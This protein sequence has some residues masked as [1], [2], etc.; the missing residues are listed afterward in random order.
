M[1]PSG[2]SSA[3][4]K[5]AAVLAIVVLSLAVTCSVLAAISRY[6]PGLSPDS[7]NYVSAA[8]SLLTGDGMLNKADRPLVHWPPLLPAAMAL[9][10][11]TGISVVWL[12]G[13]LNAAAAGATAAVSGLW[14]LR[15]CRLRVMAVLGA[16]WVAAS[17][18]MFDVSR[19][20]WSE[21]LFILFTV[22]T[23]W[24]IQRYLE[25]PRTRTLVAAGL[26]AALAS[27]T[28]YIGVT[29]TATGCLL[30]L[31]GSRQAVRKR[32]VACL[33]FGAVAG[34]PLAAWLVRNWA[35]GGTL[36]GRRFPSNVGLM[37]NVSRAGR[38]MARFLLP[39][40]KA[41][42]LPGMVWFGAM[43]GG[44]L[45]LAILAAYCRRRREGAHGPGPAASLLTF[46]AVYGGSLLASATLVALTSIEGR[47]I[48][49]LYVPGVL[50][51]FFALDEAVPLARQGTAGGSRFPGGLSGAVV[52][53]ALLATVAWGGV[54]GVW[55]V[56]RV[57]TCMRK[58]AGGFLTA[59][60]DESGTIGFLRR[61]EVPLPIYSNVPEAIG[62]WTGKK[63]VLTPRETV[64]GSD[65]RSDPGEV[66]EFMAGAADSGGAT[67]VWFD[68]YWRQNLYDLDALRRFV[69][70][71]RVARFPDA[72][73]YRMTARRG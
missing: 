36:A 15:S 37:E 52:L 9:L 10:G 71:E 8:R 51:V 65:M 30:F 61:S 55:C 62:I 22:L 72:T 40:G 33:L 31:L 2:T 16:V 73:V 49:P 11:L 18:P 23:L 43:A 64:L 69:E 29:V 27:L 28:R 3:A 26:L 17:I 1:E 35:V 38:G 44:A 12:G 19:M 4:S 66:T 67:L 68:S 6:G 47:Y 53:A 41:E 7:L 70:L 63:A 58:G 20:L 42:A 34:L 39:A 24:Q 59:Q 46:C 54:Y 50:L 13:F 45:A 48:A 25:S 14:L 56:G 60:W 21:P 57:A 32:L 5:R